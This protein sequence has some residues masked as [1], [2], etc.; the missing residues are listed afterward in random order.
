MLSRLGH[1]VFCHYSALLEGKIRIPLAVVFF[2]A[3]NG[4]CRKKI[5]ERG[6]GYAGSCTKQASKRAYHRKRRAHKGGGLK[7]VGSTKVVA[8]K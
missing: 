6:Q 7:K 5:L 8:S 3:V 1:S 2:L 4:R